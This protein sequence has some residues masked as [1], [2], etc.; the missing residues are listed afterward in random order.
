MNILIVEDEEL[1]ARKLQ[2]LLAEVEPTANVVGITGSVEETLEWF[3]QHRHN[4]PDLLLLDIELSDGKSF[5]LFRQTDLH[6]PVI[7]TTAYDEYAVQA[8]RTNSIDYLLK[9]VKADDLRR[10]LD[11]LRDLT[12]VLT[13]QQPDMTRLLQQLTDTLGRSATPAPGSMP[14][15]DRFLVKQGQRLLSI[16]L[17][18]VAYFFVRHKLSFLK[19]HQGHEWMLDYTMD[20]VEESLDPKRFFRLNRQITA[21]V[22]SVVR[23]HL[24]YNGKLKVELTPTFEED[25]IVS[26]EKAAGMKGWLGE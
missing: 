18:E 24:Y 1:T 21:G 2:R 6:F 16:P 25:V 9:P 26:R 19:T 17:Q 12:S 7:F 23:V 3:D 15:K 22:D 8:F 4:P 20:E 13:R 14:Y 10:A 5:E 11:K